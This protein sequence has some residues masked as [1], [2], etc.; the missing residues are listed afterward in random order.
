MAWEIAKGI[1]FA[2]LILIGMG[3]A[4]VLLPTSIRLGFAIARGGALAARELLNELLQELERPAVLKLT[5]S[6]NGWTLPFTNK[7]AA[8]TIGILISIIAIL[9]F[10][11]SAR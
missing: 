1:I 8:I 10:I 6:S 3:V 4:L 11:T 9:V 2:V 5:G 7:Q